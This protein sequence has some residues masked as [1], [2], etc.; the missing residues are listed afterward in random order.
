MKKNI[1]DLIGTG[2][3][4]VQAIDISWINLV[5]ALWI[6]ERSNW[7]DQRRK[8]NQNISFRLP[9]TVHEP[10]WEFYMLLAEKNYVFRPLP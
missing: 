2:N 3:P 4:A 7:I 6:M 8:A 5:Y 9:N 10:H 1:R